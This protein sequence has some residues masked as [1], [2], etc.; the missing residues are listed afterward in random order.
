MAKREIYIQLL[1]EGT[2]VYRPTQ[3]E[4]ISEGIY[5]VLPTANYDPEDEK[6]KFLPRTIVRCE[7]KYLRREMIPEKVLVLHC[8]NNS[9]RI[10]I[11]H[12]HSYLD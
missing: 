5:R 10:H 12:R 1:D 8:R 2:I 3:G 11:S 9:H 6:W 7:Q 4:E